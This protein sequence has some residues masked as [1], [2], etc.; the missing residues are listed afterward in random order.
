MA[1][2]RAIRSVALALGASALVLLAA[3]GGRE[4]VLPSPTSPTPSPRPTV[5][6]TPTASAIQTA[7]AT[8]APELDLPRDA[9]TA[10]AEPVDAADLARAGYAWL[11][12]ANAGVLGARTLEGALTQVAVAWYRGEDPFARESGLVI[13]Q[14]FP[15]PPAWRAVFAATNRPDHGVLGIALEQEDLTGDGIP[16]LLVR[17]DMGGTGACARWRVL[18][19]LTGSAEEAWRHEACD[20][21]VDVARGRLVV[22]E[23]VFGPDDPHCCPGLFRLRTLSFDGTTFVETR[24]RTIE[25][26]S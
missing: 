17:E 11:L 3:C 13:W 9:P 4:V 20:T 8:P 6:P 18:V 25:A 10:L 7:P 22:Q 19:S 24:A 2:V 1:L 23:A 12:P 15:D 5:T 14:R 26:G 21:T 16:D